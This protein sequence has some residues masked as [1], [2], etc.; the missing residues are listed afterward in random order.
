MRKKA[1]PPSPLCKYIPVCTVYVGMMITWE[2]CIYKLDLVFD[3]PINITANLNRY[4][5]KYLIFK[6]I[7]GHFNEFKV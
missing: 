1:N 3:C 5:F 4:R 6:L 2:I 7:K